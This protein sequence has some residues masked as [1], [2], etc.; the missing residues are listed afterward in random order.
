LSVG[1]ASV[2]G[3]G[4]V[5]MDVSVIIPTCNRAA[6]LDALLQDLRDQRGGAIFEMLVVDNRSVDETALSSGDTRLATG[7]SATS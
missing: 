6:S 3:I 4:E 7:A 5:S 2:C 1:F